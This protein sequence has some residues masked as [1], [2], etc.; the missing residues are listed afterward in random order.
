MA[1]RSNQAVASQ[2]HPSPQTS[3]APTPPPPRRW[4]IG[5]TTAVAA[6]VACTA[7]L[8]LAL[9]FLRF[10]IAG[11]F[12]SGALA[13]RGAEADFR[14]VTLDFGRVVLRDVRFGSPTSPDAA[15]TEVEARWS[16]NG[17]SPRVEAVRL[18]SPQIRLRVDQAGRM[19]AGSLDRL[20]GGQGRARPS[21]PAI[22]LSIEN[23]VLNVDAPFGALRA[24]FQGAGVLGENFQGS[25]RLVETSQAR[26][27]HALSRGSADLAV[28]SRNN[29]IA[30]RLNADAARLLWEGATLDKAH[31]RI[32]G[33][34]PLNL[35][36]YDVEAAWRADSVRSR[37]LN[38]NVLSG[39]A[40]LEGVARDDSIEPQEWRA[41]ARLNAA[42]FAY[43]S[44]TLGE[45]RFEARAEGRQARGQATWTLSGSRFDGLS[46][47]SERPTA[48]GT[49]TLDFSGD[50]R[51]NGTARLSLAQ[52]RL[53]ESAQRGVRG[54]FPDLNG[55]PVGPTFAQARASLDRAADRFDLTVPLQISA[56]ESGFRIRITAPADARAAS[57]A[58][59]RLS[60]LRQD[61]PALTL[62]WPGAQLHG[63]IA[64]E[65]S[66][67]GAPNASLLLDTVDWSPDAPFEADGTLTLA[68]WRAEGASI[69][70]DDLDFGISFAPQ[71][72]GQLDLG[73]PVHIT[74]PLGDG[75]VRDLAPNLNV[76]V[77][78]RNGWS[79]N[80]NNGCLPTRLGGLDAAGLSFAN[81][82]FAL[83]PLNG[84]LI[85]ANAGG[86]LSGGFLI[87]RLAL[88]G[89]M[90]GPDAQPA[91][92]SAD[93]VIGRF[94]GRS[95]DMTLALQA[96]APQL[97]I[98]LAEARRLSVVLE[99][100]TAN[101][102]IGDGWRVDGEFAQ[103]TLNDPALPGAVSTIA[104]RW[105]AAPED[106]KPVIRVEAAE[107][108][109]TASQPETDAERPLFNPIRLVGM[110]AMLREGQ[111][112]ATGQLQLADQAHRL[113]SFTAHHDIDEGAGVAHISGN[114]LVFDA[115][116][117]P[118][119]ISEKARGLVDNVRG[120]IAIDGDITWTRSQ[121]TST[122]R[123]VLN[124][125]SLATATI[126]AVTDVRGEVY[127]NDLFALT[128]PPGQHVTIGSLNPGITV[129]NGDVRFQLLPEGRVSIEQAQFA[130][131][132]GVLAMRPTTIA[133]GAD[134]T[135]FELTLRD[136]DAGNLIRSL[137]IPDLTA[138]GRVEGSFPLTLTRQSAIIRHG[139]L[140]ALPP[141][142]VLSYTG[143][144]GRDAAGPARLAFDALREFRYDQL[145]LTLDGDL[146]GDVVSSIDLSGHNSG[147]AVDLGPIIQVPGIGHVTVRGVPFDFNIRLT[148]PFRR[149]AQTA[150]SVTDPGTIINNARQPADEAVDQPAPA[151]R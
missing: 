100:M 107:A 37:D 99:R 68:N 90:A 33:R 10:P 51:M 13:E 126:P 96:D 75:E 106:D 63:A 125:V 89:R 128:T 144:V 81:G 131:G 79:V 103:G 32:M 77:R 149:L 73:G 53:D 24:P 38:A 120:P 71:G 138:T 124:G 59:L 9:W 30:F 42:R 82:A 148:A 122:G 133:L 76:S 17:L 146:S 110:D 70:G 113:A 19:S 87:Q 6:L 141:G 139:V 121:L 129:T 15:I 95:G 80:T 67:G 5:W 108:L 20:G 132:G 26:G 31:V 147:E 97:A 47:V 66:G 48:N 117:Q 21:L 145:A 12:L 130:L 46:L 140:R 22:D 29:N 61:A 55:A 102:H 143:D 23:G 7:A 45:M 27:A 69:A 105:S 112:N 134:E 101:A 98:D 72:G 52:T 11:F 62:Q 115:T 74:G 109:L 123:T 127:F 8:G 86:A 93:N 50:E 65:L 44:N 135:E 88:N 91:R 94:S 92:L 78:W 14:I 1:H 49:V 34:T 85:A 35:S 4:L 25:A 142:G 151:P 64:L 18:A 2:E 16:W 150:A 137:N 41:E 57:G 43:A 3:D 40:G 116:L 84:A 136:V 60:P 28:I 111:I 83:C 56:D 58:L 36:R 114:D 104:G 39:A 54:A 119:Q 118:Y